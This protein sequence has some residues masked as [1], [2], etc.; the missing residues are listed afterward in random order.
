MAAGSMALAPAICNIKVHEL[1]NFKAV[2]SDNEQSNLGS[3]GRF[4]MRKGCIVRFR[5]KSG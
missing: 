2:H 3:K 5:E 1:D 4:G